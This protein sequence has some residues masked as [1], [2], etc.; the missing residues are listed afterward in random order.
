[1][2]TGFVY[3]R[4]KGAEKISG[5]GGEF[6]ALDDFDPGAKKSFYSFSGDKRIRIPRRNK[7]AA[8]AGAYYRIRTWRGL[9]VMAAGF[10]RDIE[11]GPAAGISRRVDRADFGVVTSAYLRPS[12]T[13]GDTVPDDNRADCGVR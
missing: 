9:S 12:G 4:K 6:R 3:A 8:Y 2:R 7:D 13:R 10:K 11:I 1:M 5:S